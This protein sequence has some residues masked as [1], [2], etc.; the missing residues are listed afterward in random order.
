MYR[1]LHLLVSVTHW[2]VRVHYE[3]QNSISIILINVTMTDIPLCNLCIHTNVFKKTDEYYVLSS[4][5]DYVC[6]FR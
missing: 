4:S 1:Q 2:Q 5:S 6:F 3:V